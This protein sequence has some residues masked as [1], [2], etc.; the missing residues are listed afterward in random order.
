[1]SAIQAA[2]VPT[3]NQNTTGT[4]SNVTGTVAIANG[5]TGATSAATALS[6]LGAYPSSNPNGYTSNTGTVISV[7]GTGTI[8]GLTL[9]GTVTSSGSLTLGGNLSIT[10]DMIYN[11][12]TATASQTTFT[13]S[14]T[15]TSGK[16]SV[17]CNG[18]RM[19]NGSDVTVTSG[20]SVVFATALTAGTRVDLVYPI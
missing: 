8:S 4:A 9:T 16:I 10:A 15:Y 2:D 14:N 11:V 18:I 6:N 1:M 19:V 7:S 20:T 3:L 17:Y 13:T 5:G 12:F